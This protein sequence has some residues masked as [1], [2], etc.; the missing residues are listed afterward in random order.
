MEVCGVGELQCLG[1]AASG[2]AVCLGV[3]IGLTFIKS[4]SYLFSLIFLW[5]FAMD[6]PVSPEP[7]GWT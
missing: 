5:D 3:R 4:P 7:S 1:V 2:D 6:K